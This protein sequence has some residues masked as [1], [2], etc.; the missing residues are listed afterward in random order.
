MHLPISIPKGPRA[1]RG[2]GFPFAAQRFR[3][4]PRVAYNVVFPMTALSQMIDIDKIGSKDNDINREVKKP[5]LQGCQFYLDQEPEYVLGGLV[6]AAAAHQVAFKAADEETDRFL[7]EF[8]AKYQEACESKEEAKR[9]ALA[10]EL[11][12]INDKVDVCSGTLWIPYGIRLEVT[13]GQHR[14]LTVLNRIK[15]GDPLLTH[16]SQGI[17]AMVMIEPRRQKRQQDF[18]DLGQTAPIPSSIKTHMDY[19]QP[20]TKLVKELVETVPIF[21]EAFIEFKRPSIRKGTMNIYSLSN[22]KTAVQAMLLG[23]TRLGAAEAQKR[24]TQKLNGADYDTLRDKVVDFYSR[25]SQE[26]T[27]FRHIVDDPDSIDFDKTRDDFMCLN[28]VGLA[29]MGMVGHDAVLNRV[30]VEQA[31]QAVAQMN[32]ARDNPLWEG[33]LRVGPGVARGGNVIE[34]GGSIVKAV[35][36]LPLTNRDIDRLKAVDGF[37]NKLPADWEAQLITTPAADENA[38]VE[39]EQDQSDET[40]EDEPVTDEPIPV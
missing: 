33:T 11:N 1:K 22:L 23:N 7:Q 32:W 18:V 37:A 13:D 3:Q 39:P 28:S 26:V 27:C 38:E 8:D 12:E 24:L 15:K 5:H 35:G 36:G 4:G 31:V 9:R 10:D 19:R 2:Q 17:A 20:V 14:I 21:A 30:T 6:L 29:V 34:L 25:L 40:N 16:P